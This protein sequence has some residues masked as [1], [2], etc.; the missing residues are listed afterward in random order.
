MTSD[1]LGCTEWMESWFKNW[2]LSQRG[3]E[4]SFQRWTVE[5]LQPQKTAWNLELQLCWQIS[6]LFI[7]KIIDLLDYTGC[8]WSQ[9]AKMCL[10]ITSVTVNWRNAYKFDCLL[11]SS[12]LYK[13]LQDNNRRKTS[14]KKQK[15]IN[16]NILYK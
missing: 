3:E 15:L 6:L 12:Y 7:V 5:I 11:L 8:E 1:S 10:V 9:A 14:Y 13:G 4:F 2:R 16:Y